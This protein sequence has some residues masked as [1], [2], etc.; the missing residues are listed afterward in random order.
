[1]FSGE[2]ITNRV[3]LARPS[4]VQSEDVKSKLTKEH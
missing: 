1:M 3:I 2:M 4:I